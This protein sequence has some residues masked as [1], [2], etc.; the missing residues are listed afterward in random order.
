MES[1]V[2]S[3]TVPGYVRAP[4]RHPQRGGRPLLVRALSLVLALLLGA[5]VGWF[6]HD[7]Y[8]TGQV[9]GTTSQP[10]PGAPAGATHP[11]SDGSVV[12]GVDYSLST[13]NAGKAAR[14][15]V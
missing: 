6:A 1:P 11:G 5:V 9:P 14:W 15:P 7:A 13:N 4:V 8:A 12:E 3:Y 2:L 10:V